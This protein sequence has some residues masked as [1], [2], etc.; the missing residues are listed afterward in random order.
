MRRSRSE[1]GTRILC[2]GQSGSAIGKELE[3][4]S[5]FLPG[6]GF[7]PPSFL[8]DEVHHVEANSSSGK[9]TNSGR[10]LTRLMKCAHTLT[11]QTEFCN[12]CSKN[13]EILQEVVLRNMLETEENSCITNLCLISD[14]YTQFSSWASSIALE[15]LQQE[16]G[17]DGWD[18]QNNFNHGGLI[19]VLAKPPMGTTSG[20]E[21]FYALLSSHYSLVSANCTIYRGVEKVST[22]LST[23]TS[24]VQSN[25]TFGIASDI[26]PILCSTDAVITTASGITMNEQDSS[27]RS[28]YTTLQSYVDE[29]AGD[30]Y[31]MQYHLWPLD[32]ATNN[33]VIIDARSSLSNLLKRILKPKT[34]GASK[35]NNSTTVEYNSLRS[36]SS[37]VHAMHLA[38]CELYPS[39]AL[40]ERIISANYANFLIADSQLRGVDLNTGGNLRFCDVSHT[41]H[42]L[43]V[44]MNWATPGVKWPYRNANN[45]AC[46]QFDHT[47]EQPPSPIHDIIKSARPSSATSEASAR[48]TS[49]SIFSKGK[50]SAREAC[51]DP[52]NAINIGSRGVRCASDFGTTTKGYTDSDSVC[53]TGTTRLSTNAKNMRLSQASAMSAL[54][55]TSRV[56]QRSTPHSNSRNMYSLSASMRKKDDSM[57]QSKTHTVS[58]IVFDSPYGRQDC[59]HICS[60]ARELLGVGAYRHL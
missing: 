49:K 35:A 15:Y 31:D 28:G 59:R 11:E 20:L 34:V 33:N 58:S 10:N 52:L 57:S 56:T 36:L 54:S 29:V 48:S 30:V 5:E 16:I 39:L 18:P 47:R 2:I 14:V 50:H 13:A 21:N 1:A 51:M 25:S 23:A 44:S 43:S 46:A 45:S 4:V 26:F 40:H 37:N 24:P 41:E 42:D 12:V 55:G 22:P 53:T 8:S 19:S 3:R 17:Y 27:K 6:V 38:Y 7:K 32:T 60:S 9:R